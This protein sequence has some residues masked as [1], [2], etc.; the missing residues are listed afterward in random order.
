MGT[1]TIVDRFAKLGYEIAYM[2]G[3]QGRA[4][5]IREYSSDIFKHVGSLEQLEEWYNQ[6]LEYLHS[7]KLFDRT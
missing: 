4:W 2:D 3:D 7:E 1:A 5:H 6:L